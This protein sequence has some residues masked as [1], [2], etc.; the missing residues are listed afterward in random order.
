VKTGFPPRT[1]TLVSELPISSLGLTRGD[2]LIVNELKPTPTS[3]APVPEPA[4]EPVSS[5]RGRGPQ[6]NPAPPKPAPKFISPPSQPA[7][8]SISQPPSTSV[9]SSRP[10]EVTTPSGILVHRIVPDDNSCLFSSVAI[11]FEQDMQKASKMRESA[12]SYLSLC[13]YLLTHL[14]S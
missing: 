9:S 11:V 13:C 8:T 6:P 5:S 1:I 7:P 2:Q 12:C 3:S 4:S 14:Q 10:D